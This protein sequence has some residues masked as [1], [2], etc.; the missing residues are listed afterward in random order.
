MG[1]PAAS[2]FVR[3][4]RFVNYFQ[5]TDSNVQNEKRSSN[6]GMQYGSSRKDYADDDNWTAFLVSY[7]R[8]VTCFMTMMCTTFIW[9]IIMFVLLPW[10]CERIKQGNVY[11]HITGSLLMWILG[12]PITIQGAEYS[13]TKA[14]YISNHASPL[15]I[16]LT[17]WLTPTGTVGIAKKEVN[18][19][20]F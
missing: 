6:E 17:M 13:K 4:R 16:F 11:G 5:S 1:S 9:G 15:D 12:N 20:Y 7:V 3:N 2:F 14:I 19:T 8:I 18:L 10:P